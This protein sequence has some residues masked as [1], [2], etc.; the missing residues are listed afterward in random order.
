MARSISKPSSRRRGVSRRNTACIRRRPACRARTTSYSSI[1]S[2][3]ARAKPGSWTA[4]EE[5]E[6]A[7]GDLLL[8]PHD[9]RHLLGSDLMLSPAP[10]GS[11]AIEGL[12]EMRWGGD[13]EATRFICGY[14][15]CD[16]R[17][18]ALLGP[19][20]AMLR[21]PLGD[22]SK[23]GWLGASHW[24]AGIARQA[25]GAPSRCSQS[26]RNLLSSKRCAAMR[27]RGRPISKAGLRDCR[28]HM[29]AALSLYCMAIRSAPGRLMSLPA[30]WH[31][32]A[33]RLPSASPR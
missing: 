9:H 23:S 2:L 20:P 8:F 13:G 31:C 25:A 11:E 14:L 33:R 5:V 21:I 29:S 6:V 1:F 32:H 24:R 16:R 22:I 28:I 26:F 7:A 18:R 15:A 10:V 19:L 17:C 12:I 3:T 27:S 30:R 4:N